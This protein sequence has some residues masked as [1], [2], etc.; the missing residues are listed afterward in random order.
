MGLFTVRG[1]LVGPEGH[2]EEVELLVDTAATLLT[3]PKDLAD[4]LGVVPTRQQPVVTARGRRE[5]WPVGEVR[6][7]LDGQQV[8]TPC[9]LAPGGP[10]LLGA[11][12]LESL[13]LAVDPVAKKLIPVE[14][15]VGPARSGLGGVLWA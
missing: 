11:V 9:F 13:F 12:A 8:T 14:G 4:R 2:T 6:L 7:D 15:F 10:V 1:R 5:V 3:L